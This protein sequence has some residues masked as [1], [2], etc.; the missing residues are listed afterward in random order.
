MYN[1]LLV[2]CELYSSRLGLVEFT[3]NVVQIELFAV[4]V[5]V[6]GHSGF[7]VHPV[8]PRMVRVEWGG[9]AITRVSLVQ[10]TR[11]SP[12]H[13][14]HN[15]NRFRAALPSG[16]VAARELNRSF[17]RYC[18]LL[19]IA[20]EGCTVLL[21]PTIGVIAGAIVVAVK[22]V[23]NALGGDGLARF[24]LDSGVVASDEEVRVATVVVRITVSVSTVTLGF[25]AVDFLGAVSG[26]KKRG[27]DC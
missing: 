21:A 12:L 6:K 22:I 1:P 13:V 14:E 24:V 25:V 16:N 18:R 2:S 7:A 19:H 27:S 11:C 15:R 23:P 5:H 17:R 4:D 3:I 10:H 9:G 26:S 20:R 8:V